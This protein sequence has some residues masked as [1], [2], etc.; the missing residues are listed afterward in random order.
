M[1]DKKRLLANAKGDFRKLA[2]IVGDEKAIEISDIFGGMTI[3]IP[4]LSKGRKN[5]RDE[6][7]RAEYDS[8]V[9]VRKL[10]CKY[11][12]CVRS[13]YRILSITGDEHAG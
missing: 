6:A 9:S 8:K 2:E 1:A 11:G 10:A 12:L 7:I 5:E 4:V 3:F 13:I